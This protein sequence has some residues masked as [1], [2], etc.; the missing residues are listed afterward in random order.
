MNDATFKDSVSLYGDA[1]AV[2]CKNVDSCKMSGIKMS[3]NSARKGLGGALFCSA[4]VC[5]L[6]A[7]S[8]DG[9]SALHGGAVSFIGTSA[10]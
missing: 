7:V 3:G 5:A 4:S 1:G 2:Q 6:D 9:N 8:A 10:H